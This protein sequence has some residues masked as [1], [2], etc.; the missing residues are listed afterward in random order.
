MKIFFIEWKLQILWERKR[1]R[2]SVRIHRIF[3]LCKHVASEKISEITRRR[4]VLREISWR[5]KNG[6]RE[7]WGFWVKFISENTSWDFPTV[8]VSICMFSSWLFR[9][10]PTLCLMAEW[11]Q[12][13]IQVVAQ[14][15]YSFFGRES[16]LSP[17]EH[18]AY[19]A[20][21]SQYMPRAA[22][23]R[24]KRGDLWFQRVQWKSEA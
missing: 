16:S 11:K 1:A 4:A 17:A 23:H 21:C 2:V 8:C 13:L 12:K 10:F 14:T 9:C 5:G 20:C 15:I 6:A 22:Y 24:Q 18:I 3:F 19:F 7:N